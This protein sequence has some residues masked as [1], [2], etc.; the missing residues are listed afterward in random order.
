M[1]KC[2]KIWGENDLGLPPGWPKESE[3]T[4]E[5]YR[6]GWVVCSQTEYEEL[7]D[8][9]QIEYDT[10]IENKE[11]DLKK[12]ELIKDIDTKTDVLLSNGFYYN[13][14]RICLCEICQTKCKNHW[15]MRNMIGY[16]NPMI[17]RV[18]DNN[19]LTFNS[20]G[21]HTTFISA[22]LAKVNE[23]GSGGW[24]EIDKVKS[25]TTLNQLK[26]YSDDR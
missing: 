11:I 9:L 13:G 21:E 12:K 24:A 10:Y 26:Q 17:I 4:T 5:E 7:L 25:M 8:N 18:A 14:V 22:A 6:D 1:N 3:D 19:F 2:Y 23:I 20:E 15:D 16:N